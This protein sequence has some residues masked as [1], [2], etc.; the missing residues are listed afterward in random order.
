[1]TQ[2]TTLAALRRSFTLLAITVSLFACSNNNNDDPEVIKGNSL[3]LNFTSDYETGLLRWMNLDSASLSIG[4]ILFAQDSKVFA[5]GKNIFVLERIDWGATNTLNCIQ[6]DNIG[7]VTSIV[8]KSLAPLSNP[9]EV[10]VVGSTGYI[11]LYGSDYVQTFDVNTCALGTQIDLPIEYA[12]ASSIKANGNEL[13]V[14]AQRLAEDYSAT[15]PGLLIRINTVTDVIDTIQLKFYN[16]SSAVLSN[17]KLYVSSLDDYYLFANAGVEVVDLATGNSEVLATSEQLGGGVSNIALDESGQILYASVYISW[18]NAPVKPINLNNN[19]VGS[20]LPNIA[21]AGEL[22]FDS[23]GNKLFIA[24]AEGL[25]VYDTGAQ[26]TKLV[27]G[28]ALQPSS[29]AIARW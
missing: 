25:K 18:G 21:D 6:A 9:Y 15:K 11:A 14:V 7:D 3:L 26:T 2:R 12:N 10:A 29:L 8:Q 22:V 23:E 19:A 27:G 13:L 20:A 28:D 24:E 16:P 5:D 1:M 4:Q 17:G